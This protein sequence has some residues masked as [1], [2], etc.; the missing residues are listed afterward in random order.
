MDPPGIEEIDLG[1]LSC[2]GGVVADATE[3]ALIAH[4]CRINSGGHRNGRVIRD[5]LIH[6]DRVHPRVQHH[7]RE[8]EQQQPPTKLQAILTQPEMLLESI[9]L[10]R[11]GKNA[12]LQTRCR[13]RFLA[14]AYE[15]LV[16]RGRRFSL[17]LIQMLEPQDHLALHGSICA[18]STG[19]R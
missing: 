11:R 19:Q 2:D 3:F 12:K 9:L 5:G 13:G 1:K 7:V 15:Q 6:T 18:E 14:K 8:Q 4:C 10:L 16:L 17:P